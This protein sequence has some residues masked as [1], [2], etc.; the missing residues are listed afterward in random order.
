MRLRFAVVTILLVLSQAA[1]VQNSAPTADS[2]VSGKSTFPVAVAPGKVGTYP[3]LVKSGAGY[4]YDEVLE[5]RVW[6]H[7]EHEAP[8][9]SGGDDYYKAFAEYERA[10][11]FSKNSKGAEEPLVLI[12]QM[13]H[14]NEPKPGVFEVVSGERLAEWQVQWLVGSKRTPGAVEKFMAEHR[15]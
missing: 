4:F 9:Q 7:P 8:R 12:R 11:V 1:C 5:Y 13:Q 14:V 3:A 15:K 10:L 6:L 2:E